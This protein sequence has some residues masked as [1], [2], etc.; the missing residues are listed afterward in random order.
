MRGMIWDMLYSMHLYY[1]YDFYN[2]DFFFVSFDFWVA[3]YF[4]GN[5]KYSQNQLNQCNWKLPAKYFFLLETVFTNCI[6][7]YWY[8]PIFVSIKGFRHKMDT[9][10][11]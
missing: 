1:R 7:P 2:F 6:V 5:D 9:N 11:I 8:H 4:H 3:Q 10:I